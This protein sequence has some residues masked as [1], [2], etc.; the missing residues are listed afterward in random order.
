[1]S[2]ACGLRLQAWSIHHRLGTVMGKSLRRVAVR[3]RMLASISDKCRIRAAPRRRSGRCRIDQIA[4]IHVFLGERRSGHSCSSPRGGNQ[5]DT[6]PKARDVAGEPLGKTDAARIR[7][8][9]GLQWRRP[10]RTPRRP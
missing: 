10:N 9:T 5:V 2:L 6:S 1:M 7:A 3:W 8:Q 4:E